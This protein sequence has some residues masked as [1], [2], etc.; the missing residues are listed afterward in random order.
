[1]DNTTA[2]WPIPD[3]MKKEFESLSI[4]HQVQPLA[5]FK[6]DLYIEPNDVN[7]AMKNALVEVHFCLRHYRIKDKANGRLVDSFVGI[8]QQIVI[9]KDGVPKPPNAYKRKNVL[10]GPYKPKPFRPLVLS[11]NESNHSSSSFSFKESSSTNPP[12]ASTSSEASTSKS[13]DT[14]LSITNSDIRTTQAA[15]AARST[16][17]LAISDGAA[18]PPI[19]ENDTKGKGKSSS[20]RSKRK[21]VV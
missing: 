4:T 3:D 6:N 16:D 2:N 15:S 14:A 8:V 21:N 10:E 18:S 5:A 11:N 17:E 13:A 7:S 9:L 19:I 20:S 1:M 12:V